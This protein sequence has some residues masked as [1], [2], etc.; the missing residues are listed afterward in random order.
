MT[1]SLSAF[2]VIAAPLIIQLIL[3]PIAK[4]CFKKISSTLIWWVCFIVDTILLGISCMDM[5]YFDD[6]IVMLI[7][8][9]WY[10]GVLIWG[11]VKS[12]IVAVKASK[13]KSDDYIT[14]DYDSSEIQ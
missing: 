3:Y 14:V 13:K 1:I 9:P 5:D 7:W 10:I 11:I 8:S 12:V 6:F 4:R 2:L